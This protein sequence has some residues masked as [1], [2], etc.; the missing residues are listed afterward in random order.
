MA[1]E[2]NKIITFPGASPVAT[3]KTIDPDVMLEEAKGQGLRN[4]VILGYYPSG[5]VHVASASGDVAADVFLLEQAKFKYVTGDLNNRV[6]V[7]QEKP[8]GDDCA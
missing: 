3:L 7:D 8:D 4:M 2:E 6:A 5:G 1:D